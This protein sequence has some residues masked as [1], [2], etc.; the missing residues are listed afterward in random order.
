MS[1]ESPGIEVQTN[2]QVGSNDR[3]WVLFRGLTTKPGDGAG[4]IKID[5]SDTPKYS[6]DWCGV[7]GFFS[8]AL[9]DAV[10]KVWQISKTPGHIRVLV[11]DLEVLNLGTAGLCKYNYSTEVWNLPVTSVEFHSTDTASDS[12][13]MVTTVCKSLG[14]SY[15]TTVLELRYATMLTIIR[16]DS[17]QNVTYTMIFFIYN[18]GFPQK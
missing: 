14:E 7:S 2:S 18:Y 10:N 5:L 3:L 17:R 15:L 6:L 13:R 1:L 11:N 8:P 4:G 12:Y 9:P 16:A